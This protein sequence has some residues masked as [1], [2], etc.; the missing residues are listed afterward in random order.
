MGRT[1]NKRNKRWGA[2]LLAEFARSG[3]F[4]GPHPKSPGFARNPF[5]GESQQPSF[6]CCSQLESKPSRKASRP[7]RK[8]SL[9]PTSPS[10]K[11]AKRTK[12]PAPPPVR[13]AT[14]SIAS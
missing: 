14:T 6:Y 7:R 10:Q 9:S 3:G 4:D 8:T 11:P 2:P 1:R 13:E 5:F 12:L